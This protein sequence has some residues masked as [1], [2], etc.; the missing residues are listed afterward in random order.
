[1]KPITEQPKIN[2]CFHTKSSIATQSYQIDLPIKIN[3][4]I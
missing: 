3:R 4:L 2:L 1:M